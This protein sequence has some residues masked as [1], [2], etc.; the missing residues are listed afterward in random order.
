MASVHSNSNAFKPAQHW[1]T[2]V[3]GIPSRTVATFL[4]TLKAGTRCHQTRCGGVFARGLFCT[5]ALNRF[6]LGVKPTDA[7]S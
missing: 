4:R 2:Y 7:V 5:Q 1:M 6:R 3:Q